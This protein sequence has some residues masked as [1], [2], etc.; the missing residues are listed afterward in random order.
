MKAH[1]L[2][3]YSYSSIVLLLLL[4]SLSLTQL[5]KLKFDYSF[6][7]F[8][9]QGDPELSHYEKFVDA[10][11]QQN[12]FLFVSFQDVDL[13]DKNQ[14]LELAVIEQNLEEM[15]EIENVQSPFDE[16]IYQ[17][18]PFGLNKIQKY[19]P[20]RPI[21]INNQLTQSDVGRFF[22]KSG[23]AL[24]MIVQHQS[25]KEKTEADEFYK[26]L[27]ASL[28]ATPYK[29]II[30][31]KIQMQKDFTELLEKELGMLLGAGFGIC[32]ITLLLLF[33][34]FKNVLLSLSVMLLTLLLTLGLMGFLGKQ[35]DVMMVM[36]PAIL[37]IISLSDAIH[38]LNKFNHQIHQQTKEEAIIMAFNAIGKANLIT[39]MTTAIG[40]LGL[41]FLPIQPI[42]EFG[43]FAA[44]GILIAFVVTMALIPALLFI[45]SHQPMNNQHNFSEKLT[46]YLFGKS[47]RF[48]SLG[49]ILT[50]IT[51]T[52][53]TKINLNTGLIVGLQR[54]EPMLEKVSY[55]DKEFNGYRPVEVGVELTGIHATDT[56]VIEKIDRLEEGMQTFLRAK[57]ILSTNT[58]LKKINSGI[59]GG[60]PNHINLPKEQDLPRVTRFFNNPSLEQTVNEVSSNS[61]SLLRLVGSAP[62]KGSQFYLA[63]SE[64]F[65]SLLQEINSE[66]FQARLTGS[67]YL[68]DKTDR[69]VINALL[70]GL[71]F[72]CVTVILIT[73]FFYRSWRITVLILIVNVLPLLMLFGL[74]GHMGIDLNISTAIIF[75]V[76][77]GI[78]VDDS[79]HFISRYKLERDQKKSKPEALKIAK[80]QTGKSI[81]FTTLSICL[82]F[83]VLMLSGFSAVYYLGLFI[84]LTAIIALWFD[85]RLLPLLIQKWNSL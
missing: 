48:I 57:D 54:D 21:N 76:A 62:D 9:P 50:I 33:R 70:K 8:F 12:D 46:N 43:L 69:Y 82:G 56:D 26:Q 79:I 20:E 34:S 47:Y 80:L 14:L 73:L 13:S 85:L 51:I 41:Y 15:A 84:F 1:Q 24:M 53:V 63:Q 60:S 78:A 28:L 17:I 25:F 29:A 71:A 66:Q 65:D 5:S 45:T 32:L 77:F 37:L 81:L 39:S 35:I 2:K 49:I 42:K 19:P 30:S 75:T 31:G 59:Y 22:G 6:D 44:S 23:D 27:E 38:L 72:A 36:L 3:W 4:T 18:T 10:F 11:G 7:S 67:S 16:R 61:G 68:I 40:F 52:G 55:F 83:G 58:I 74:M 64:R